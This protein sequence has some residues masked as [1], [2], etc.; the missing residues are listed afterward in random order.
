MYCRKC[1]YDL[2][3]IAS[4]A[5]PECG[6][7]FDPANPRT[8]DPI[9][10]ARSVSIAVL[11]VALLLLVVM[12]ALVIVVR[13]TFNEWVSP[14]L[15][16]LPLALVPVGPYLAGWYARR[17]W[18]LWAYGTASTLFV[19][20]LA[21][22]RNV[23]I[24]W[25]LGAGLV[26]ASAALITVSVIA[27]H[28][29]WR[30]HVAW[31][32]FHVARKLRFVPSGRTVLLA[33]M[34]LFLLVI[35]WT[36]AQSL[37]VMNGA[38]VIAVDHHERVDRLRERLTGVSD[39]D[40]HAAWAAL[41]PF[42]IQTPVILDALVSDDV[43]GEMDDGSVDFYYVLWSPTLPANID[44]ERDALAALDDAGVGDALR[45]HAQG[46][47]GC[48]PR[49][50]PTRLI[51]REI[52]GL[53][54]GRRLA[55]A[56]VAA[57]RIALAAGDFDQVAA[58]FDEVM[59][60]AR[61]L[62]FQGT[63]I[64][65]LVANSIVAQLTDEIEKETLEA[66][67]PAKTCR[68]L[69]DTLDRR[70]LAP[71]EMTLEGERAGFHDQLQQAFTDNGRGD[72]Y[73]IPGLMPPPSPLS[74]PP[75][76]PA[77][78]VMK[79]VYAFRSR[80]LQATRREEQALGDAAM[81]VVIAEAALPPWERWRDPTEIERIEAQ[82]NFRYPI[83]GPLT[84]YRRRLLHN[85]ALGRLNVQGA[86][87]AIA[88]ELFTARHGRPPAALADLVPDILPAIPVDALSGDPICYRL[89]DADAGGAPYVLYS[90]GTDGVDDGGTFDDRQPTKAGG[91]VDAE[92][93]DLPLLEPR[94]DEPYF[95]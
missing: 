48:R 50:D 81:D 78:G 61:T 91:W 28:A 23:E 84:V 52:R 60:L 57:M 25:P 53:S 62:S 64:D 7:A 20:L 55:K 87:A 40:A 29:G 47:V 38:P 51:F 65:C 4:R 44:R 79:L 94:D 1:R 8:F 19:F 82:A 33:A 95:Y 31:Y 66:E 30:V 12:Q 43:R 83:A 85:D 76:A 49:L 67:L 9:P 72:G 73:A 69:L 34:A 90:T 80:F 24:D 68:A 36:A 32:R 21:L 93:L 41:E 77:T 18:G 11:A 54:E 35:G 39:D 10:Q 27:S 2:H 16:W 37:L 86:R 59:A 75:P 56:R 22:H 88:I 26:A 45:A 6:R 89:V 70:P 58:I 5:C 14:R 74:G 17:R 63:A 3:A 71:I 92:G 46:P 13:S 42:V 15:E